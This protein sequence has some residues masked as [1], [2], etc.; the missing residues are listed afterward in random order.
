LKYFFIASYYDIRC[1]ND[2]AEFSDETLWNGLRAISEKDLISGNLKPVEAGKTVTLEVSKDM[3]APDEI[4]FF[5]MRSCDNINQTSAISEPFKLILD[6][7]PP[8]NVTDLVA[9]LLD[10]NVEIT[11]TAP[12]D[13]S[14][15][16][17][18]KETI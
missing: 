5:A 15:K 17:I 16:G 18:G 11:F 1:S 6:I 12:G 14:D 3:F 2:E 9:T 8:G 7:T 13:D 4:I 10:S